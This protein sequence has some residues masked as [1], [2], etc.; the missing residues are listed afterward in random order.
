MG[1]M[2]EQCYLGVDLGA[3]SGRVVQ[4]SSTAVRSVSSNCTGL[5]TALSG[6]ANAEMERAGAVAASRTAWPRPPTVSASDPKGGVDTWGVDYVLM[7]AT[8]ELLGLPGITAT[9][10]PPGCWQRLERV[11]REEIFAATGP[12]F[13][14]LNTL[15]Q[16]LAM[17][18]T[19]PRCW[20]RPNGC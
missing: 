19:I 7:S 12:Q 6:L 8:D 4:G 5:P 3:E 13:M 18:R 17:Q 15:Y 1:T 10:G 14:E 20:T 9:A 2:S 11:P 16:L